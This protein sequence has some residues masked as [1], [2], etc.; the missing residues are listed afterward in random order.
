VELR[1]TPLQLP[2]HWALGLRLVLT[3][4][5][6]W[7]GWQWWQHRPDLAT[8][9]IEWLWCFLA[10]AVTPIILVL[11]SMKWRACLGGLGSAPSL[12]ES[13]KSY[14]GAL[15]LA[16]VTPGRAGELARPLY[17]RSTQLRQVEA[18]GRLLLDNWT[19]TLAVL[20][21]SLPGCAWLWGGVGVA[22]AGGAF[23]LLACIP[24]WLGLGRALFAGG[25][26]K[27]KLRTVVLRWLPPPEVATPTLLSA[28]M[29]WGLL[30]YAMETLQFFALL[31]GLGQNEV[32]WLFLAGGLALVHLANS[33]QFTLAGIGPREGMTVWLL[34][35]LGLGASALLSASSLQTALI[36]VM[37]ALLGLLIKPVV[38]DN[39]A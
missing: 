21:W 9:H 15:P 17:F 33:V 2:Q 35:K 14:I 22:A 1:R 18:S 32:P 13:L 26:N 37:P 24:L 7:A 11:R 30:A 39:A 27:G 6:L 29:G 28:C 16:M 25:P 5:C 36:L 3:A 38:G 34:V 12:L 23:L 20:L 4:A 31:K 8:L 10:V 19:D